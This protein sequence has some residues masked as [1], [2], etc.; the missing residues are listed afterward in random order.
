MI[1]DLIRDLEVGHEIQYVPAVREDVAVGQGRAR[2]SS[3]AQSWVQIRL[4]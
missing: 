3:P 4:Q 1:E 2:T